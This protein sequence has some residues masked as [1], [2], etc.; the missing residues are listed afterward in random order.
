MNYNCVVLSLQ[1]ERAHCMRGVS[2]FTTNRLGLERNRC[3]SLAQRIEAYLAWAGIK[4]AVKGIDGSGEPGH[5]V[6]FH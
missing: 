2:G 3:A 5:S 1:G 4:T 6:L